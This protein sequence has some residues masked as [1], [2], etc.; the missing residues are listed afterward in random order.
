MP[1]IQVDPPEAGNI[2]VVQ[3]DADFADDEITVATVDP[4]AGRQLA[5]GEDDGGGRNRTVVATDAASPID[6]ATQ[7]AVPTEGGG[8]L[9]GASASEVI[10]AALA[11]RSYLFV[12]NVSPRDLWIRFGAVATESQPSIKLLPDAAFVMESRIVFTSSVNIIG[13]TLGQEFTALQA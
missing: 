11:T 4:G 7:R 5:K 1:P 6:V 8:A 10:F 2:G 9:A 12:Q 3:I 13:D